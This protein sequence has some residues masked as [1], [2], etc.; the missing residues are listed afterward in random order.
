VTAPLMRIRPSGSGG[1]IYM[2]PGLAVAPLAAVL[3]PLEVTPE[4]C[5]KSGRPGQRYER[6]PGALPVEDLLP[7]DVCV[8]A[9]LGEF[10]QY[11]EVNP[12]QP[13]RAEPVA[14][15]RVVQAQG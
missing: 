8:P 3:D 12:A 9:M 10:A 5:P 13:E 1:S 11:V 14:V 6:T 7:Q 4:S 15:D 2:H